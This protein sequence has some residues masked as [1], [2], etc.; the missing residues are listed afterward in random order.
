MK[1][2]NKYLSPEVISLMRDEIA[3]AEGNEVFFVGQIDENKI[4]TSIQ[5]AA[6]GNEFS[7]LHIQEM[8]ER[9]DVIIHNHPSGNLSPSPNDMAIANELSQDGIASYIVDNELSKVYA[10][11]EPI[12][13]EKELPL[14]IQKIVS[15]LEPKGPVSQ[16]MPQYEYRPQQLEMVRAVCQAFNGKKIGVIEAGTGVGKSMAYLIPA[17]FWT[18]NNKQRC[19]VSTR[20]INLQEQL[21]HKDIPFLKK[22]LGLKFDAV[23]VKGRGNYICLRK[24]AALKKDQEFLVEDELQAE[25]NTLLEWAEKTADGSKSDLNFIPKNEIWELLAAESDNCLRAQCPHFQQ[26]FVMKARRRANKADILVANHHLLFSDLAL[27]AIGVENSVL[28]KYHHVVFDEAHNIEDI[29]TDYFGAQVTRYGLTRIIY[30]LFNPKSKKSKGYLPMLVG[31]IKEISFNRA[32]SSID[33]ILR[34]ILEQVYPLNDTVLTQITQFMDDLA[35]FVLEKDS[36]SW[37]ENKIRLTN[38]I[39]ADIVWQQRILPQVES[40]FSL[41]KRLSSLLEATIRDMQDLDFGLPQELISLLQDIGAQ[42]RRLTNALQAM[43][44]IIVEND[45]EHVRWIEVVKSKRGRHIVRLHI[46]PLDISEHMEAL[47]FDHFKTVIMTSA[48]L[49][50]SHKSGND[51][52]F[53]YQQVGLNRITNKRII[54]RKIPAPFDYQQQAVTAIPVD[55]P[56]PNDKNFGDAIADFILQA[57]KISQGRAFIL[58][59]SYSLLNRVYSDLSNLLELSGITVYKQGQLA[60]SLLLGKFKRDKSSVLFATDSF[61]QGVDVEGEALENVIITKLPFKVP[62]EPY[63]EA[64]V[65]YIERHGGNAFMDYSLPHAVLKLKQGFG[66]LIRKKTDIGSVFILDKRIVEK[67]YGKVFLNSL[68]QSRMISG[69]SESVLEQVAKFFQNAR[70]RHS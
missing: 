59:T 24:M 42:K 13:K 15:F 30:R 5:V 16:R 46:S 31:K 60:R 8:S 40:F 9:S 29:A 63:V 58:F 70:K 67:F 48:T 25:T 11:V 47:V 23:L 6:R 43:V 69:S 53:F 57:I 20:T 34:K 54:Q 4:V 10:I 12:P 17:I 2:A 52:A 27:R 36:S 45:D 37:N 32:D 18:H 26:C 19:V 65:E 3:H 38:A 66:R 68:P 35:Q 22:A 41:L 55:L 28:P 64:R 44:Q 1:P 56:M 14:N 33:D 61:W 62:S 39:R 51:F 49:A 50:I 7:V 21:I